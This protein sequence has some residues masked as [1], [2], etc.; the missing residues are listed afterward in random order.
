MIGNSCRRYS[1]NTQVAD[2]SGPGQSFFNT[3]Q[4]G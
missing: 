4:V 1:S 2:Q 3:D